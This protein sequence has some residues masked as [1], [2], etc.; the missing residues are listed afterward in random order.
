MIKLFFIQQLYGWWFILC[1]LLTAL[2]FHNQIIG[3][4]FYIYIFFDCVITVLGRRI[5]IAL[6]RELDQQ[7]LVDEM[8]TINRN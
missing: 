3:N 5:L 7:N 6:Y 2:L 8:L 4:N 1:T